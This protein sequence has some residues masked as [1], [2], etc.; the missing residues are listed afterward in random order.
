MSSGS[1]HAAIA[2]SRGLNVFVL[3]V[4]RMTNRMIEEIENVNTRNTANISYEV[5]DAKLAK[6]TSAKTYGNS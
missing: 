4:G 6:E 1:A 5:R 3:V 2:A